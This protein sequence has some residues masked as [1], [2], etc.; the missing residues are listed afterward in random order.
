MLH[1][2][3]QQGRL[4]RAIGLRLFRQD[5]STGRYRLVYIRNTETEFLSRRPT[6]LPDCLGQHS[7]CNFDLRQRGYIFERL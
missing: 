6:K 2:N 4:A 3:C 7:S 5:V 1:R